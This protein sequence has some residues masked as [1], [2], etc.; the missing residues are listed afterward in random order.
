VA[1]PWGP[2]V[3]TEGIWKFERRWEQSL[4]YY[5][6]LVRNHPHR[7]TKKFERLPFENISGG[8]NQSER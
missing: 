2:G 6:H 8:S 1:S 5:Q 3:S 4:H 7:E